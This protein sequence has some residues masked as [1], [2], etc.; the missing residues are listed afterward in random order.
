MSDD[1]ANVVD[2]PAYR[3]LLSRHRSQAVA[4]RRESDFDEDSFFEDDDSQFTT[5]TID[6]EHLRDVYGDPGA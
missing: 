2:G 5:E 4:R 6:E 3:E 1:G